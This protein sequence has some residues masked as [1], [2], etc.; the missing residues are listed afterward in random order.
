[1]PVTADDAPPGA[2]RAPCRLPAKHLFPEHS[3]LGDDVAV[4]VAA[5]EC[6]RGET[7][8]FGLRE[9]AAVASIHRPATC[10]LPERP[11]YSDSPL[12]FA[13]KIFASPQ[14][15]RILSA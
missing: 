4:V 1:E 5:T 15:S 10:E 9:R 3:Y 14:S 13:D 11:G 6:A 7:V 12:N 8:L 2:D